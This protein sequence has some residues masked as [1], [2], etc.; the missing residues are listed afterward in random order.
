MERQLSTLEKKGR[1]ETE[2]LHKDESIKQSITFGCVS[3]SLCLLGPRVLLRCRGGW[4]VRP[5]NAAVDAKAAQS[6][7]L[8]FSSRDDHGAQKGVR[9]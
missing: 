5:P 3:H 6:A 7:C 9:E 2:D 1:R 8:L 4:R